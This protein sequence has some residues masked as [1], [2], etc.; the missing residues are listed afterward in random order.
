MLE[1]LGHGVYIQFDLLGRVGVPLRFAPSEDD[2]RMFMT[3]AGTAMVAEA[4]L[5][6]IEEGTPTGSCCPKTCAPR[7]S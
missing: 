7:R 4:I 5:R 2:L 6:L 3:S 1:L